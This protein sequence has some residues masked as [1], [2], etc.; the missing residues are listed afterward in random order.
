M[1][2]CFDYSPK[3]LRPLAEHPVITPAMHT[4]LVGHALDEHLLLFENL[5][6]PQ[7]AMEYVA[8]PLARRL[9]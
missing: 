1:A 7:G 5:G 9:A 8:Q 2:E 6:A 3:P 4:N